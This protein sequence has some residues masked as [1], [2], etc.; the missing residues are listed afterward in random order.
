MFVVVNKIAV[1]PERMQAMMEAFEREAPRMK[2]FKGYL[3]MEL[4]KAEDNSVLA[5]SRWESREA[6][7]EYT[8]HPMFKQHHGDVS[9]QGGA[10]YYEAKVL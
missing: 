10:T 4:W 1:P 6:V 3:G 9:S 2:H 7:D 5:V 8:N